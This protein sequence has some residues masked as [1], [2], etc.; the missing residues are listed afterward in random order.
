MKKTKTTNS[1][2]TS[3]VTAAQSMI[4]VKNLFRA[5]FSTITYIRR[6]FPDDVSTTTVHAIPTL[7][8]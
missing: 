3:T 1:T 8:R 7:T 6:V 5:A 4:V 2:K